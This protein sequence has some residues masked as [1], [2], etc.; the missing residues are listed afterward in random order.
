[1]RGIPLFAATLA[2][3]L[4]TTS[5]SPASEVAPEWS[6]SILFGDG[7]LLRLRAGEDT[8]GSFGEVL[9]DGHTTPAAYFVRGIERHW[10]WPVPTDAEDLNEATADEVISDIQFSLRL[11]PDGTAHYFDYSMPEDENGLITATMTFECERIEDP[12]ITEQAKRPRSPPET[13]TDEGDSDP[14]TM[15]QDIQAQ[16]AMPQVIEDRYEISVTLQCLDFSMPECRPTHMEASIECRSKGYNGALLKGVRQ[17]G[18]LHDFA[19]VK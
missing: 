1:M 3:F 9:F 4:G 2:V 7:E 19:C 16:N 8:S 5:T 12:K 17:P 11:R 6:C 15:E 10:M 13:D 18:N 14:K